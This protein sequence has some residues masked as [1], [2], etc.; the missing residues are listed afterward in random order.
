MARSVVIVGAGIGGLSAAAILSAQ[1]C[2]VTVLD[3]ADHLGGKIRQD[4]VAGRAIDAGPT[5]MTMRWAL[6]RVFREAGAE[7]AERVRLEPL[8][9]LARHHWADGAALDLHTDVAR[10]QAAIRAL[11]GASDAQGYLAFCR[12]GEQLF[13]LVSGPFMDGAKPSLTGLLGL[14]GRIGAR[15]ALALE[16]HR[17]MAASLEGYFRDARLR[18]LFGRFATYVGASPYDAPATLN[19]IAHVE[20]LGVWSVEGGMASVPLALA[21]VA[22]ERGAEL[23]TGAPVAAIE[24][25][26]GRAVG[27]RLQGGEILPADAVIW[28]GDVAA[29]AS[30]LAGPEAQG[31]VPST[32]R[33]SLSAVTFS[34]VARVRGTDLARHTVFFSSDYARE[35]EEIDRLGIPTEPTVYVCA[36]DRG[37]DGEPPSGPERLFFIVNARASAGSPSIEESACSTKVLAGLERRFG[38]SF[39][40]EECRVTTPTTFGDRFPATWGALYGPA[41]TGLVSTLTRARERSRMP[42][43]YLAGGSAHPGPGVP[44]AATSGR[45]A[46]RAVIEDLGST[47]RSRWTATPGGMSTR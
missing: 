16:G 24:V 1:G 20:R 11:S 7:L 47:S 33:R 15:G 21:A 5:V 27:V 19:V 32:G 3:R 45:L 44:M 37:A 28:N 8:P 39:A 13:D 22:R 46:A 18:Q 29:L 35:F 34:M 10:S 2:R 14:A 9:V 41:A 30:G 23:R 31:A 12:H 25:R 43:L 40:I 6:E 38:V 17:T 36:Q 4:R 42:G 26:R